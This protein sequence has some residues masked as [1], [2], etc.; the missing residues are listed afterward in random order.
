[1][2]KHLLGPSKSLQYFHGQGNL[3]TRIVKSKSFLIIAHAYLYVVQLFVE[4]L[5]SQESCLYNKI[6][7][8]AKI[9]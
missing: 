1:M 8:K 9:S 5:S 3:E 7:I 4:A 2:V 6:G